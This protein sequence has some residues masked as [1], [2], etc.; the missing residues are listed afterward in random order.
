MA[1]STSN[2]K[3]ISEGNKL[4]IILDIGFDDSY[5]TGGEMLDL[6]RI[7]LNTVDWCSS[8]MVG[9]Y[10]VQPDIASDGSM[11]RFAV[12]QG[13]PTGFTQVAPGTNLST[14]GCTV[15]IIGN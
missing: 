8:V 10:S 7:G 13:S 3:R 2:E 11:M 4:G 5:P 6:A 9:N 1:L 12:Y 14:L 15:R